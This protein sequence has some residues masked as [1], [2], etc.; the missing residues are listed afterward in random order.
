MKSVQIILAFLFFIGLNAQIKN[1][2]AIK[3]GIYFIVNG[4]GQA[5]EP[6]GPTA[7]NNVFLRKFNK[8]GMQKWEILPQKDGNY[9]IRLYESELYLEPHPAGE[10]TAWLDSSK[11]GYKI[12]ADSG[13]DTHWYI[14]SKTRKGDAMRSYVYSSELAT[15]IRFEPLEDDK[16]FKWEFISAE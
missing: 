15:E 9:F 3:K 10:R 13:S 2:A 12:V 11:S 7:G 4:N 5:I 16:K 14:K 8:S 1:D 6:L